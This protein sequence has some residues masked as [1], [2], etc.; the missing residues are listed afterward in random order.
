MIGRTVRNI[1]GTD[2]DWEDQL[3]DAERKRMKKQKQEDK[4]RRRC[5]NG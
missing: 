2:D 1:L 5:Y 4:E 3:P